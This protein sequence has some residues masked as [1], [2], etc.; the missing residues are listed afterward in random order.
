[1][2]GYLYGRKAKSIV[3]MLRDRERESEGATREPACSKR[4]L[5]IIRIAPQTGD[6]LVDLS[7]KIALVNDILAEG[8][9]I[10]IATDA[11]VIGLGMLAA[12]RCV[13]NSLTGA[14]KAAYEMWKKGDVLPPFDLA[15]DKVAVPPTHDPADVKSLES[16]RA[17]LARMYGLLEKQ[18][19][20]EH[21][22]WFLDE[23]EELH[24]LF[25]TIHR[26]VKVEKDSANADLN[27]DLRRAEYDILARLYKDYS[28]AQKTI[29][30]DFY[31]TMKELDRHL[32]I[33][34]GRRDAVLRRDLRRAQAPAMTL[35][36]SLLP[37]LPRLLLKLVPYPRR[38]QTIK[39]LTYKLRKVNASE[40]W[41]KPDVQLALS[42]SPSKSRTM[43]TLD[44]RFHTGR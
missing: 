19:T 9:S 18:V 43:V 16:Q 39:A 25:D 15:K 7:Q 8:G 2:S 44:L 14:E 24:G 21:V 41:A 28:H 27:N 36:P 12:E 40:A 23:W 38:A 32:R 13:T 20:K 42:S 30:D 35:L 33:L 10:A 26:L 5:D 34:K 11:P 31:R 37:R 3:G 6:T 4:S 22:L 29:E 1:M 17:T